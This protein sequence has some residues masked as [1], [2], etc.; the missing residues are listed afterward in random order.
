[1][2]KSNLIK[3]TYSPPRHMYLHDL[4]CFLAIRISNSIELV[5][6][7]NWRSVQPTGQLVMRWDRTELTQYNGKLDVKLFIY[8][9]IGS[10]SYHS[11]LI[12]LSY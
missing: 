12:G 3:Y 4:L 1:M 7:D 10:V 11:L 5:D 6:L 8:Q 2:S 9:E